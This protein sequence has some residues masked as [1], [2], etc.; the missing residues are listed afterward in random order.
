MLGDSY[1]YIIEI[2]FFQNKNENIY[3]NDI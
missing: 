1:N 3:V 2:L